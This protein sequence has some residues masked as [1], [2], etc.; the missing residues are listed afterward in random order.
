MSVTYFRG[1]LGLFGL[2][3]VADI[4]LLALTDGKTPPYAIAA[5]S[6]ALGLASIPFVVRSW[7]D[8]A[9]PV[10]VLITLRVVSALTSLPAFFVSDVP[11][12][13]LVSATASVALTAVGVLL[14]ARQPAPV[15]AP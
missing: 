6:A 15:A 14:V 1:G 13:A 8:P 5:A 9:A 11:A 2:L 12:P 4:A 7:R 3:S 10:R